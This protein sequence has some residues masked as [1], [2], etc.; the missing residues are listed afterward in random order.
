MRRKIP[1]LNPLATFEAAARHGS[2]TLAAEELCVTQGAV[3]RGVVTLE[4]HLGLQLFERHHRSVRLTRNG[5]AYYSEIRAGFEQLETATARLIADKSQETLVVRSYG[6]FATRW[7]IPRFQKF[8][9]AN[10]HIAI[11]FTASLQPVNFEQTDVDMAIHFGVQEER[12]DL[13]QH[14]ILPVAITPVCSPSLLA[15]TPSLVCPA[16]LQHQTLIHTTVRPDDWPNW[17]AASGI[18]AD[19]ARRGHRFE[20]SGMAY[21][22]AIKGVGVAMAVTDFV[23]EDIQSGVLATPF[24]LV[25][26]TPYSYWLLYPPRK[27]V[28]AGVVAFRSWLLGEVSA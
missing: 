6:T 8:R 1:P 28:K 23:R 17:L 9:K 4:E 24:D 7:L 15:Q 21:E 12:T 27:A 10:P 14:L 13:V 19:W 26:S 25:L 18:R 3:S 20:T 16:D 2:F 5:H 11:E 22:A